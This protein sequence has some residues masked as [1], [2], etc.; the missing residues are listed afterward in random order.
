MSCV[1]CTM[2]DGTC[3]Y[4]Y[5]GSAPHESFHATPDGRVRIKSEYAPRAEW[6]ANFEPDPEY[7]TDAP[8]GTWTLCPECGAPDARPSD[9]R[10]E[11]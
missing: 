11:R 8:L 5:Y 9:A 2:P 6:P 7:G 4:P 10:E 3:A 1:H